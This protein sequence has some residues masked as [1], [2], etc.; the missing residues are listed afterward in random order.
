MSWDSFFKKILVKKEVYGIREP[1]MRPTEQC[2][3]PI[4][5]CNAREN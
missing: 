3:R 2:M 4:E 1:C 5:Q